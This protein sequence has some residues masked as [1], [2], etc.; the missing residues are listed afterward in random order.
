M[1]AIEELDRF[2]ENGLAALNLRQEPEELY[3]PI[4]YM[5]SI[6]GKRLRP[7]LCLLTYTLVSDKIEKHIAKIL[8]RWH[9]SGH[10]SFL[11]F[12]DCKFHFSNR[13]YKL[14]YH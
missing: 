5:V 9:A 12:V 8:A 6:G 7:E 11:I 14:I 2:V 10:G 1:F 3:E 13:I 4:E